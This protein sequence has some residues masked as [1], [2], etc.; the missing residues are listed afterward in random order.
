[1][2]QFLGELFGT[3]TL[4][5]F[6]GGVVANVLLKASKGYEA[7]WLTIATGWGIAVMLGVFVA[8][9]TGAPNADINPAVTLARYLLGLDYHF[10]QMLSLMLA[11]LI[12]GFLGAVIVW[13]AYLPHWSVTEDSEHKRM[14]FCT[15]PA[16]RHY[17]ANC[18]NEIIGT[19]ILIICV[20][21]IFSK[22]T[23][24]IPATLGPYMV[25]VLVWGIG[26]SLG[27]PTGYAINPARDLGPRIAFAVLP[28]ANKGTV[29]WQYAWVPVVG[30]LIGTLLGVIFWKFF[31]L[32][33]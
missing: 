33:S 14:I 12:G 24:Q 17:P 25:G 15:S 32:A 8:Q 1:M 19:A 20:G 6:G 7:G 21:A 3:M 30:P 28:I 27:G 2:Q 23:G 18:L 26:L 9:A 13:L 4:I 16:I 10:W 31:L 11:E 5:I 22:A 29:D